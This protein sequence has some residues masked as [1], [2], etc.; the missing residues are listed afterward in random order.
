MKKSLSFSIVFLLLQFA[1]TQNESEYTMIPSN[2]HVGNSSYSLKKGQGYYAN[3]WIFFNDFYYGVT[4]NI[5]VGTGFIPGFLFKNVS[6]PAWIKLKAAYPVKKNMFNLSAG[7]MG[8]TVIGEDEPINTW[9]IFLGFTV[10]T[11]RTNF[12]FNYYFTGASAF[13]DSFLINKEVHPFTV[14]GRL[15]ISRRSFIISDNFFFIGKDGGMFSMHILGLQTLFKGLILDYGLLIPH[16]S[17][18]DLNFALPYLGVK[19]PFGKLN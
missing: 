15:S 16:S 17:D 2:Y 5:A 9:N 6:T 18:V 10:G 11:P 12:S 3:T 1:Y 13:N 14:S 8:T 4:D 19:I 7:A